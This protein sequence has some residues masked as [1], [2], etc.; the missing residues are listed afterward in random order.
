MKLFSKGSDAKQDSGQSYIL[1]RRHILNKNSSFYVQE[2]Y[3][4]LRTNIRFFLSGDGCKRFC[5]TSGLASEGK[6]ITILNLAISFAETGAKVLLIDADLRRP[7][8]ARLLIEN[9]SPGLSN[10]LAGLCKPEEAI[11]KSAY[12]NLDVMFSGEIPPNPSELLGNP[13]MEKTIAKLST[14]YDYILVDTPPVGVVSDVCVM[15]Q[16][17]DG[18]LFLVRQNYTE[19]DAVARGIKQLEISGAKLM[20]FVLNGADKSRNSRYSRKYKY[21]SK[22]GYYRYGYRYGYGYGYGK[23]PSDEKAQV[24]QQPNVTQQPAPAQPSE[25]KKA[26]KK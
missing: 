25:E 10:V 13:R 21:K 16:H 2:A 12:N 18:V 7:S 17:L 23:K 6:S 5:I 20:G 14:I 22:Y 19:K 1:Q 24:F 3:K 4:T 9:A 15:A 11:R 26:A 8:L